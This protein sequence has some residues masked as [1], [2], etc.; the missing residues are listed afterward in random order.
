MNK[1]DIYLEPQDIRDIIFVGFAAF[2]GVLKQDDLAYV[3]SFM[4]GLADNPRRPPAAAQGIRQLADLLEG[5]EPPA[6]AP[7]PR[8]RF[9][10]VD[11][12]G[13]AA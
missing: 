6:P 7:D 10:L 2:A 8:S 3:T 12:G 5:K 11:G 4:R 9:K 1:P 13:S